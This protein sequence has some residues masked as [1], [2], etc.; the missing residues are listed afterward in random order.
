MEKRL[1]QLHREMVYT[2][3]LKNND[4]KYS[5]DRLFNEEHKRKISQSLKS[6]YKN[7]SDKLGYKHSEESRK[8]NESK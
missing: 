2:L 3:F 5:D 6:Y 8:K 1:E 4:L 7:R